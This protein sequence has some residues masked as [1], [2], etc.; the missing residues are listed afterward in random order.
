[1][2]LADLIDAGL[3]VPVDAIAFGAAQDI[4]EDALLVFVGHRVARGQ[5]QQFL[6]F[7]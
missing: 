1:M 2:L 5:R 6:E 7:R 4:A 3:D